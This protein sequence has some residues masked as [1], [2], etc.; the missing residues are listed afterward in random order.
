M[1]MTQAQVNAAVEETL[2][3]A[4]SKITAGAAVTGTGGVVVGT[5]ESVDGEFV[6][7]KLGSGKLVRLPRSG[8]APG[9][10]GAVIGMSGAELEAAAA[11]AAAAG[12][13]QR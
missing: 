13:A 3:S 10:D 9:A 11:A 7:L 6:T 1:A 12:G 4:D 5:I 8:I 2:A